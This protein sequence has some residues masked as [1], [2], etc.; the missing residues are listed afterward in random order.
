MDRLENSQRLSKFDG[1]R[2]DSALVYNKRLL[3]AYSVYLINYYIEVM[4]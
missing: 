4:F 2:D 3:Y 1:H